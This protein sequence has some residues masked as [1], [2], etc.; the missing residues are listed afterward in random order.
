MK[1]ISTV[2]GILLIVFGAVTLAYHGFNYNTQED[3]LKVGD[4]KVTA[5]TNKTVHVPEILSGL[6]LA[7]GIGLLVLDR[8]KK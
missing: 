7:I 5:Q 3:V 4:L 1:S 6:C 2:V 8:F